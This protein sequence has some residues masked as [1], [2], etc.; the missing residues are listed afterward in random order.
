[1][2]S[3]EQFQS[4]AD[5]SFTSEYTSLIKEQM[6]S[7]PLDIHFI[8]DFNVNDIKG[9]NKIFIY[10]HFIDDFL[11]K[12]FDHLDDNTIIITHNSDNHITSK[13]KKFLDSP[14]IKKWYCQNRD[15]KHKKL[16]TIPI[17]IANSQWD[18]GNQKLIKTVRN[19]NRS[20]D[21]LVYKQFNIG[22]CRSAREECD[23]ITTA[24]GIKMFPYKSHYDYWA[25][26][27][28]SAFIISPRGNGI[29]CH[30]IWES[31]YL[32]TV[33]VLIDHECFSEF[34]HLPI[35]KV[36][37]KDWNNITIEYLR[38]QYPIY[39]DKFNN[40]I[41]ELDINWWYNRIR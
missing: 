37:E 13:Y 19:E 41:N 40:T 30:R 15:F 34:D 14:K 10:T 32:K 25:S 12:F 2:I 36:P 18:H 4:L 27:A 24:N 9:K 39:K 21:I 28:R 17:G 3:G 22:T 6:Q 23:R 16:H 20:K 29:D 31:L 8:N 5:I 1:M 33:P 26:V 38:E 11:D 7:R 35:L